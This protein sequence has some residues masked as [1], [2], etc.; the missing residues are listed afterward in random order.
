MAQLGGQLNAGRARTDDCDGYSPCLARHGSAFQ[1][2]RQ[3]PAMKQ[4]CLLTGVE[5]HGMFS[6]ALDTEI[7][8]GAAHCHDQRV[9]TEC[10][11][12]DQRLPE[13]IIDGVQGNGLCSPVQ[14]FHPAQLEREMIPLRLGVIVQLLC[15][16]A[17][18][19]S[20]HL[21]QQW[22][23]DVGEIGV[24]QR[25][26]GIFRR[27]VTLAQFGGKFQPAGA[28]ADDNDSVFHGKT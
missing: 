15:C 8:G 21:M 7:I 17:Q 5:K 27:C 28:T 2:S 11:G 26:A 19:T 24:D 10:A 23:P 9:V 4:V 6:G 16:R 3:Q 14:S 22:L 20:G 1:V 13:L 18:R 25:N 12:R